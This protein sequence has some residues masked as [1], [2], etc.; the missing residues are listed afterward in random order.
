[1]PK[2]HA[3]AYTKAKPTYVHPSLQSS[4]ASSSSA[5]S[6]PQTVNQRIQQL[7][8][9]QA[10][11]ATQEQRDELTS[12]VS[13]RT[14]PPD[15]RRILHIPEVNAPKPKAGLRSRRATGGTRPPPGPAA[16]TSWLLSSRHAP[17]YARKMRRQ[18]SAG[19]RGA[20]KFCLLARETDVEYK[21]HVSLPVVYWEVCLPVKQRLPPDQSLAHCCLRVFA[22]HWEELA[23]FE[24]HYLPTIP[25]PLREALLSYLAAFGVRNC[26]DLR[27]FRILF[28][29]EE[30]TGTSGWDEV[31]LL[32]FTG[33][34]NEAFTLADLGKCLKRHST[35]VPNVETLQIDESKIKGKGKEAEVVDSWE[36]EA[37]DTSGTQAV[38][39]AALVTPYFANL[40][41]LSLARPG[42]WASWPELLKISPNLN[43]VTHLSLAYWPRPSTTPNA[44]TTSMVSNIT[45]VSLG[46]SHFYSDL[47]DDW[48]EASNILRRF[49]VNTYSLQW[50][51]LEGCFWL[52]ALSWRS[53]ALLS[54]SRSDHDPEE[55]KYHTASPGP[56]WND[57]WRRIKY[58]NFF[59]GWIPADTQSLQNIP[60][61][62]VPVQLMRWL[63]ENKDDDDVSWK[64]NAHETG[65]AVSEWISREKMAR[66]VRQEILGARRVGEGAWCRIDHGWG[67]P[68]ESKA[69]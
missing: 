42:A 49:S 17:N 50:L 59:Q 54:V 1:M 14:V 20:P 21:V 25:I 43:K 64:L 18:Q 13:S 9:E 22:L 3:P 28:Q 5:P 10:P 44:A 2:K 62:M 39:T 32:D 31:R 36:E 4:R 27:S 47:D 61:G 63:R 30:G 65:H 55:W 53:D 6:E 38:L 12:V 33:L 11:R 60:A 8:R 51:D 34:L 66:G 68:S 24:Q 45:T 40:S 58:L 56:D 7:R 15:L 69:S 52:K 57:A 23:E 41:R 29:N 35:Q 19:E 37:E 46:G 48:Q 26:L 16:P 67:T